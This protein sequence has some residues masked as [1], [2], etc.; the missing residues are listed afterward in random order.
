MALPTGSGITTT[1]D[2]ASGSAGSFQ[3]EELSGQGRVLILRERALPYKPLKLTGK[4]RID[5][6]S[7]AGNPIAT[8]QAMGSE[9]GKTSING[10]WK[11]RFVAA[12]N[13]TAGREPATLDGDP[14]ESIFDLVTVVD[15]FR[16]SGQQVRVT[17]GQVIRVGMIE[18][19]EHTWD[20]VMD[21]AWSITFVWASQGEETPA[22]PSAT[23]RVEDAAARLRDA[24][25][26]I[27][28]SA[29]PLGI[30][31][32]PVLTP[33]NPFQAVSQA[34]SD[35]YNTVADQIAVA[36]DFGKDV[37]GTVQQLYAAVDAFADLAAQAGQLIQQPFDIFQRAAALAGYIIQQ[38]AAIEAS[39]DARPSIYFFNVTIPQL[40]SGFAASTLTGA[41]PVV[42]LKAGQMLLAE[43]LARTMRKRATAARLQAAETR[44]QLLDRS[45]PSEILA[46]FVARD[47]QDLRLVATQYYGSQDSWR[48]LALYNDVST[49]KLVS[50]QVVYV[51][52]SFQQ[53]S[54][55]AIPQSSQVNV[56]PN[57][58]GGA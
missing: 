20:R 24:V 8:Q 15:S 17:W 57:T 25:Q 3:I 34:L 38:A 49:S 1:S 6:T 37:A 7:Y 33:P 32:L 30:K 47:G 18:E 46:V 48:D 31:N 28:N 58:R 36:Q 41:T 42:A 53:G 2:G 16:K 52:K 29:G 54:T 14:I 39:V 55:Q 26:D 45:Q 9:E 43:T 27:A 4:M 40:P 23:V 21:V 13:A 11:D 44:A 12:A 5:T 56:A 10:M 22:N 50:G 35:V 19:F 51:P